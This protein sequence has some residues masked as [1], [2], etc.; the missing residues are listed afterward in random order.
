M[1]NTDQDLVNELFP[2]GAQ[3]SEFS[4]TGV[5]NIRETALPLQLP[6]WNS[7][8]P[9]IHPMDAWPDFLTSN[10][11]RRYSQIRSDLSPGS[12]ASYAAASGDFL[13]WG[14]DYNVFI[15]PKEVPAASA[16][17]PTYVNQLYSVPLWVMVKNWELNQ[18]FQLEGMAQAVFPNPK[19]EPRA[20]LS[21]FPFLSFAQH[22]AYSTCY[23]R[24]RQRQPSNLALSVLYL[25]SGAIGSQQLRIPADWQ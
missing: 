14:G 9:T 20:W 10:V 19:A 22:A 1:L 21:E 8:L 13:E 23:P 4:P 18:E 25:V 17:T 16:W 3:A 15:M 5:L 12:A 24:A 2:G 11:N 7:W 6:D